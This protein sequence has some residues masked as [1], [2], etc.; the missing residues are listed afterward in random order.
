MYDAAWAAVMVMGSAG[1]SSP[2]TSSRVTT[3]A[4]H[5]NGRKSAE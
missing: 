1:T 5:H 2:V 3:G 4:Q